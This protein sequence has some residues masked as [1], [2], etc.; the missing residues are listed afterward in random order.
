[1]DSPTLFPE[2]NRP[3]PP[4]TQLEDLHQRLTAAYGPFPPREVWDPLTQ[5]IYSLLSARTKTAESHALLR[6]LRDRYDG[7][8]GNWDKLRDAPVEEIEQA[9]AGATYPE[10]KAPQLKATL[11][12]ITRRSGKLSL[13]FLTRY[14]T[15]KIRS[16]LEQFPGVGVKTSGAVVNF[17]SLRRRALCIDSHH[18]RI[19]IRLGLAPKSADARRVEELL[20]AIAPAEWSPEKLDEHHSLIKLH[21]QQRCTAREPQCRR[22]TLQPVCPT[23]GGDGHLGLSTAR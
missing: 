21:G 23:G 11:Q 10:V 6:N 14:K 16:W 22:C 2:P 15:E 1:M 17:S 13:D 12:E 3:Q 7:W 8:Q 20:M 5:L 19:A 9:I 18:Q 4:D